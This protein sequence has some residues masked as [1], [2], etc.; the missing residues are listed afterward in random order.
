MLTIFFLFAS[1]IGL[2]NCKKRIIC[3]R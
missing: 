3:Y 1:N 2:L